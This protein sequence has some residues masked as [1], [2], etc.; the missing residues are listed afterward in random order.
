MYREALS[1]AKGPAQRSLAGALQY[2]IGM[3]SGIPLPR[4][5]AGTESDP[6][7]IGLIIRSALA[8]PGVSQVGRASWLQG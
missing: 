6:L 3:G 1:D 7:G 5:A 2:L 4:G 8:P